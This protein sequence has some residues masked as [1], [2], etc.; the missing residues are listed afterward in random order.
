MNLIIDIGNSFTK[1]A[2]FENNEEI[3]FEKTAICEPETIHKLKRQFSGIKNCILSATGQIPTNLP[4]FLQAEFEFFLEFTHR[5]LL[6][7][8]IQYETPETLGL[9]RIAGIAGAQALFPRENVLIIDAGT[10]ITFDMKTDEN[11]FVGGN[12]APGLNMRF[13]AL[14]EFTH[15]LPL[16]EPGKN[17][18]LGNSTKQAIINGVV[19]GITYEMEGVIA[20]SVKNYKDLTIIMTGGDTNL[21]EI[22]VKSPIFVVQN[23]VRLGLNII[24]NYNVE[25]L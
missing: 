1:L 17:S 9:D 7:F 23:L 8:R 24:L 6:P 18:F 3:Y 15:K 14:H 12:I 2:I 4:S 25:A 16:V 11:V 10:A 19:N 20:E 13:R 22:K 5:A 21:F